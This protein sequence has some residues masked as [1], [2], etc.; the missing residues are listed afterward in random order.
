MTAHVTVEPQQFTFVAYDAQEIAG[1]VS[2]LAER[3][4]V[5]NPIRVEVDETNPLG[6]MSSRVDGASS[7]ATIVLNFQSGAFENTKQLQTFDRDHATRSIGRVLLRARDRQR[8]DFADAPDD[9][10]LSNTQST[11]WDAYCAGRLSQLHIDINQQAYRYDFRNRFGFTD[12]ADARF[13][14]LWAATDLGW[15]DLPGID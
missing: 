5:S 12:E 8:P 7:D 14:A 6:R 9:A 10:D 15:H 13:D 4:G 3:L 11:S 1:L 2:D